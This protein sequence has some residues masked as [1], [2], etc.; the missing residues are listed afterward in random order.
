MSIS[1]LL[2]ITFILS[3]TLS[4]SY[5]VPLLGSIHDDKEYFCTKEDRQTTCTNETS[6]VCGWFANDRSCKTFPCA[7]DYLN[8]C[9][10]CLDP[11]V[12]S[13]T[14]TSC[15]LTIQEYKKYKNLQSLAE[16]PYEKEKYKIR[17][18]RNP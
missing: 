3:L 4:N 14:Y 12:V 10:A 6:H 16:V 9:S 5:Y 1:S 7:S 17:F 15:P 2:N 18:L 13:V 11:L 8:K